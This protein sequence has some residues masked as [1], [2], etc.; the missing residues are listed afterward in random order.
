MSDP[1]KKVKKVKVE[2]VIDYS[3]MPDHI[4][5]K[6]LL[7]FTEMCEGIHQRLGWMERCFIRIQKK[8]ELDQQK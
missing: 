1:A 5:E 2:K 8:A 3:K 4:W 7:A 6:E